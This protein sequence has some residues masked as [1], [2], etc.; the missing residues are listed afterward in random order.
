MRLVFEVL[1]VV[2]VATV[3]FAVSVY[4]I[5]AAYGYVW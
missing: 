1:V 2:A 5:L 3:V 4:L